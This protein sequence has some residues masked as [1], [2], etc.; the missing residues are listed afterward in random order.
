MASAGVICPS[1]LIPRTSLPVT[2]KFGHDGESVYHE[3]TTVDE[4]ADF[5]L[6]SVTYVKEVL[7][8]GWAKKDAI[9]WGLY[10]QALA[11]YEG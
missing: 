3:F 6:S 9:D 8:R 11:Q 2:F 7:S 5:Y 4:L 10:E 1:G